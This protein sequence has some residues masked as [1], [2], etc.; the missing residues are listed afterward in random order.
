MTDYENVDKWVKQTKYIVCYFLIPLILIRALDHLLGT[1]VDIPLSSEAE[2]IEF[3]VERWIAVPVLSVL[4]C[5]L[6]VLINFGKIKE[7]VKN[8]N[9]IIHKKGCLWVGAIAIGVLLVILAF[10]A[11]DY[12]LSQP[13]TD[14]DSC[15]NGT[16]P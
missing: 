12:W 10:G 11:F 5:A 15:I 8:K 13:I 3:G 16:T 6:W 14:C 4:W 9:S 7:M 1:V 2:Y